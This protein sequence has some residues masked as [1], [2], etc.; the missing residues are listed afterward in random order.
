MSIG[1]GGRETRMEEGGR[2]ERGEKK[3]K[4]KYEGRRGGWNLD[5]VLV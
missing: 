3:K 2:E 1:E 5:R 4:A